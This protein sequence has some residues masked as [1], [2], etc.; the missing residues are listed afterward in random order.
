M[1]AR[2][3]PFFF[4]VGLNPALLRQLFRHL[5]PDYVLFVVSGYNP[6]VYFCS[7]RESSGSRLFFFYFRRL[8]IGSHVVHCPACHAVINY[9]PSKERKLLFILH[10]CRIIAATL[11]PAG[12]Y[13]RCRP[14]KPVPFELYCSRASRVGSLSRAPA[15]RPE[16]CY[17]LSIDP[18]FDAGFF[19]SGAPDERQRSAFSGERRN[20]GK[21]NA[22]SAFRSCKLVPTL[23][24]DLA[25]EAGLAAS[26]VAGYY[27]ALS[28]VN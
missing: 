5:M 24:I 15:V 21:L 20:S 25:F 4:S 26:I 9:V 19:L 11:P 14:A 6:D 8:T 13:L 2:I 23:S 10:F 16:V 28:F 1:R 17:T 22:H 7:V 3:F 27:P 12:T 18:A